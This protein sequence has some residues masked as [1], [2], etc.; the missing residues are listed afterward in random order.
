MALQEA[1]VG[2]AD[3]LRLLQGLEV[4][5]PHIAHTGTQTADQ[6]VHYFRNRAFVRNLGHNSFGNQLFDIVLHM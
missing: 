3:E 6:L 1:C 5:R 4:L 2:D